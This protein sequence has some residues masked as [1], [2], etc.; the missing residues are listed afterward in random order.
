MKE[1]SVIDV[2]HLPGYAF[3]HRSLMWWGT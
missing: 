1:R 2:S 3:G